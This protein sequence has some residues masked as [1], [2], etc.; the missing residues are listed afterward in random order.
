MSNPI[1][2]SSWPL[3][4]SPS[5]SVQG[6]PGEPHVL[7]RMDNL[8]L[9]EKGTIR[10]SKSAN[11]ESSELVAVV[12]S[13]FAAYVNG[14]KL[15]Y[16]YD[17]AGNLSRNYGGAASQSVYDLSIFTGG[18]TQR[19]SFLNALG[20]I[21]VI[22][23]DELYMDL[24]A[25]QYT[26]GLPAPVAPTLINE[27]ANLI[28]LS[29]L[30]GSGNFT[31]W[32]SIATS[33]FTNTG[34]TLIWQPVIPGSYRGDVQTV[35]SSVV[36]TTNFGGGTGF[37]DPTDTFQIAFTIDDTSLISWF[38][39]TLF[40][41]D[42]TQP[43]G[44]P[45]LF[46]FEFD[47]SSANSPYGF[48]YPVT[49]PPVVNGIVLTSGVQSVIYLQRQFFI[50]QGSPN[51]A[52]IKATL[53]SVG[54][55]IAATN[56][57]TITL[58]EL[59]FTA[60]SVNGTQTYLC[61]EVNDTG[62][63][64]EFS[65]AS[66]QVS[67]VSPATKD[68]KVDRSGAAVNANANGIRF[69]RTNDTL[70]QFIEVDRQ[71]G[72]YGF[73]PAFF[74]DNLSDTDALEA[75]AL[76]PSKVLEFYRTSLPNNIIGMVYYGTRIIYLTPTGFFPSYPLDPGSYDSRFFYE[77]NGSVSE[78]CLFIC[79]LDVGTMIVSTTKDFYRITGDFS[80]ITTTNPDGSTDTIQN[81]TVQWLGISDPSI[82]RFFMEVEG[83]IMYLSATGVRQLSVASSSS[84]NTTLELLFR[85]ENRFGF[86]QI[87]LLP[88]DQSIVACISSGYRI[89]WSLPCSDGNN[90]VFVSTFN[91]PDPT[92][93]RG[94]SYWRLISDLIPAQNPSCMVREDDGTI[95]IGA[96]QYV[97]S[98]ENANTALNLNLLTQ[99][100]FGENPTITKIAGSMGVFTN[101]GGVVL[102]FQVSGLNIDGGVTNKSFPVNTDY[103]KLVYLDISSMGE[104]LA[105]QLSVTGTTAEFSLNYF[106]IIFVVDLPP[107][108]YYAKMVYTNFGKARSKR[109]STWPLV[110]DDL[111]NP[112]TLKVSA[113][114]QVLD[115]QTYDPLEEPNTIFWNNTYDIKAVDWQ[116]EVFS[117]LGM[118]FYKFMD[119]EILQLYPMGKLEDQVGP[120]ELD[121]EGIVF[122]MRLRVENEG[123]SI[124]YIVWDQ[125][126]QLWAGSIV[127]VPN[128]DSVYEEVF[129]KGVISSVLKVT[130]QSLTVFYRFTL[131]F[132]VRITGK[133]TEEKWVMIK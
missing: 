33:S 47:F 104:C 77:L 19:A 129:P 25:A 83:T 27:V 85:K 6:D 96:G 124:N 53:I 49:N 17:A 98:L 79:K 66:A 80:F 69:F 21:F 18:T 64:V 72:A 38:R 121:R 130:F 76:D 55:N 48:L 60:G 101:T 126:T 120:L 82:S 73:T 92:E 22:A 123:T 74:L 89:Y 44:S 46:F 105:F 13:I 102:T 42:P 116:M 9:D 84:I 14:Q 95:L 88:A 35:N 125:D 132:K 32:T 114:L 115:P 39:V 87:S 81:V 52:T 3:G 57:P 70:G 12:N 26:L 56:I 10:L 94:S 127:T 100:N 86:P 122:S 36:D 65:P 67:I 62:Q 28:D 59:G 51:W 7:L 109:I 75:A 16:I 31:N 110:V 29:N 40:C 2:E 107:V 8:T 54:F 112:V 119:P 128:K 15:R 90:Y 63:F 117:P 5:S 1:I 50:S 118:R 78:Q 103:E 68:V 30:D 113:D 58:A 91:I 93:L 71:S 108:T 23:G 131:E 106:F 45:D 41:E 20:S 43:A 24:G 34:T 97:K 99:Y 61:V 111:G 4:W 37:Q 133:E 11:P